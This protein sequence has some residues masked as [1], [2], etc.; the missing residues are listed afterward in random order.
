MKADIKN[1]FPPFLSNFH[2]II[3]FFK[4]FKYF[5]ITRKIPLYIFEFR[6]NAL[7]K[8]VSWNSIA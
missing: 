5:A 1:Q 2:K 4:A 7:V 8:L 6:E 3:K